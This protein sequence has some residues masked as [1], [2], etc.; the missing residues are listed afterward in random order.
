MRTIPTDL[1]ITQAVEALFTAT[2][3]FDHI[4]RWNALVPTEEELS[5]QLPPGQKHVTYVPSYEFAEMNDFV[6]YFGN[7]LVS[8]GQTESDAVRI[9]L[10]VYCHIM[11]SEFMPTLIWNQL[12]LLDGQQP[13]WRFT[14]TTRGGNA[15]LCEYP[16]EKFAEISTFAQ[17]IGQ[18]IGDILCRIWDRHLRNTFSHCRYWLGATHV[19]PS[20][21]LSPISRKGAFG[22]LNQSRNYPFGEVRDRYHSARALTLAVASEHSKACNALK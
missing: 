11:E 3:A 15:V 4:A 6:H 10:M 9:M 16:R 22:S 5:A 7:L 18:P 14:R 19:I 1:E 17:R 12:R 13:S 2:A 8:A 21:G 20:R